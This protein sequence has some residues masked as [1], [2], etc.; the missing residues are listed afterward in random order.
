M[1]YCFTNFF[2]IT[3]DSIKAQSACWGVQHL[4]HRCQTLAENPKF[5]RPL[6]WSHIEGRQRSLCRPGCV[7]SSNKISA[8]M[9][10]EHF[11]KSGKGLHHGGR[12]WVHRSITERQQKYWKMAVLSSTCSFSISWWLAQFHT[13]TTRSQPGAGTS[14]QLWSLRNFSD[15]ASQWFITKPNENKDC[16]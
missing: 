11:Q 8:M 16:F 2:Q 6:S 10:H 5:G 7:P 12:L 1:P 15:A 4:G 9:V 14:R 3:F 13:L